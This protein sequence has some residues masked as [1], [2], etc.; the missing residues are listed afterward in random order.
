MNILGI[1]VEYNP[2]HNGHMY[3]INKT[4]E[5]VNYDYTIAVMSGN[6]VQRGIPAIVDKWSRTEMALK[7]GVNLVIELPTVYSVS[8]AEN[9]AY[10]AIK[11]LDSLGVVDYISFGSECGSVDK[12]YKIS[13]FLLDEPYNYKLYLRKMLKSG[14]TYAAAREISISAFLG[15]ESSMLLRDPNNILGIEYIKSL[16]K[17][18]SK[19]KPITIKRIGSG[20]NSIEPTKSFAS[21]TYIRN[22]ILKNDL[23]TLNKFV[24]NFSLDIIKKCI[25]NGCGP[26]SL[27]DF[28]K[29]ILYLLRSNYDLSKIFDV[30]EGIQY[31][32][33]KAAKNSNDII[34]LIKMVKTKRYTESRIRRILLHVLLNIDKNIYHTYEGPNYVRILGFDKKG[35]ELLNIIKRKSTI[36]LITKVSKYK[37]L[38]DNFYMFE[39]DICST[40]IYTLAYIKNSKAG[41]DF[42]HPLIIYNK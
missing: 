6:F 29:I 14:I 28:G 22:L 2:L 23:K 17:L 8:T 42:S 31:R 3:H 13:R 15:N 26:V 1:I 12:L 33:Y 11:L 4:R 9:F 30:S 24:P 37:D 18:N 35:L 20:H 39:K 16:I 38:L 21:A 40:D 32:F 7:S 34:E 19:I 27:V 5:I 10:G 25:K 41:F 36:P